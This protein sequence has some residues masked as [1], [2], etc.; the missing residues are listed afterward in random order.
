MLRRNRASLSA[1][2]L[3]TTTAPSPP[4]EPKTAASSPEPAPS[5]RI[6][7]PA[8]GSMPS[9]RCPQPPASKIYRWSSALQVGRRYTRRPCASVQLG[10]GDSRELGR[11]RSNISPVPALHRG[12][13]H[14]RSVPHHTPCHPCATQVPWRLLHRE[15]HAAHRERILQRRVVHEQM[16]QLCLRPRQ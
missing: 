8:S 16:A 14:H 3:A 12:A 9:L 7:R 1:C 11:P 13:K 10:V 6:R 15:L 5:S 2:S 4:S